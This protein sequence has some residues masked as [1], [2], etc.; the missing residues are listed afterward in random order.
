M[1]SIGGVLTLS[2]Q[3]LKDRKIE[4]ARRIAETLIAHVLS[5]K[6]IEL[7]MYFDCP[8]QESELEIIRSFL[9]RVGQGEPPEYV[10]AQVE[11]YGCNL[12]LSEKV[13]IPRVE[14]EILVDKAVKLIEKEEPSGKILWD[15]CTGSGCIGL[16]LKRKIPSLLVSLSDICSDALQVCKNNAASNNLDVEILMGDLFE[17]FQGKRADYIFCNPPYIT[18]KEYEDLEPSVKNYEPV[19][20]LIG[21]DTGLEF[22]ERLAKALPDYLKPQA[23]VFLEIGSTQGMA[24]NEIFNAPFWTKK[25]RICDFAGLDRFFFLEIE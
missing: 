16:S 18:R 5:K 13:L 9:K 23:K 4:S 6:R 15:I 10:M 11:F 20:A 14:T 19:K 21:G 2:I 1:K 24:V 12:H 8:L 25:E 7:Y 17:P 3:Y 22:Y